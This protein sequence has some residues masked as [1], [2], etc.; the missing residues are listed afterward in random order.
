MCKNF[1]EAAKA[2]RRDRDDPGRGC[3][4]GNFRRAGRLDQ[5]SRRSGA[6]EFA[7]QRRLIVRGLGYIYFINRK[8]TGVRFFEQR[9]ALE[10]EAFGF[11]PLLAGLQRRNAL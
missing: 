8:R 1:L 5:E 9:R 4:I 10:C 7:H 6:I 2:H 3:E 11:P